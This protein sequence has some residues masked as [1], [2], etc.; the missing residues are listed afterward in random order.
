VTKGTSIEKPGAGQ[1]DLDTYIDK[2]LSCFAISTKPVTGKGPLEGKIVA[3]ECRFSFDRVKIAQVLIE[4]CE[5]RV[6]TDKTLPKTSP[7]GIVLPQ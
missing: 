4:M 6:R 2:I 3:G 5:E 7:G 1:L